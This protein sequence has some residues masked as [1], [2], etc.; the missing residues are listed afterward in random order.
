MRYLTI[1]VLLLCAAAIP[2]NTDTFSDLTKKLDRVAYMADL[3]NQMLA[4]TIDGWQAC[5]NGKDSGAKVKEFNALR[6]KFMS[7]LKEAN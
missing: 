4:I 2:A 5:L 3:K 6:A 1:V 7:M